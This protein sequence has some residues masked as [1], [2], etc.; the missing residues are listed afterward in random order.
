MKSSNKVQSFRYMNKYHAYYL[1]TCKLECKNVPMLGPSWIE[2]PQSLA[3]KIVFFLKLNTHLS[4]Q[5][6]CGILLFGDWFQQQE[7]CRSKLK[8]RSEWSIFQLE[9]NLCIGWNGWT[10]PLACLSPFAIENHCFLFP[11]TKG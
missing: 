8:I 6:C 3:F 9:L 10:G 5:F 4:S 1:V 2:L 11:Y 7:K